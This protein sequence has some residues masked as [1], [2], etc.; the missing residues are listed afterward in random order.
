VNEKVNPTYWH[1][2]AKLHPM[3]DAT[4][5]S[6]VQSHHHNEDNRVN[7]S[8]NGVVIIVLVQGLSQRPSI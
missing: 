8:H 2:L 4:R 3:L 5:L 6:F 1:I 7:D